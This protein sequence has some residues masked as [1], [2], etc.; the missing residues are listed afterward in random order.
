MK[1]RLISD[2]IA[3]RDKIQEKIIDL[4]DDLMTVLE[5]HMHELDQDILFHK[6]IS[7]ITLML[8]E[9]SQNHQ[10]ALKVLKVG[11]EEGI[12]AYMSKKEK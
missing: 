1:K 4:T 2:H 9:C 12:A 10:H 11:M 3:E 7:F 6:A 8:Y 5:G